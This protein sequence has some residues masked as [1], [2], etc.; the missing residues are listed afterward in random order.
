MFTLAFAC[1]DL[2]VQLECSIIQFIC[3]RKGRRTAAH[4]PVGVLE[5]SC[6]ERDKASLRRRWQHSSC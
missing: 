4:Q 3:D 5:I 6:G 2:E 1:S